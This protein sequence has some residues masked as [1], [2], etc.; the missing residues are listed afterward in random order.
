M[1]R[2][3]FDGVAKAERKRAPRDPLTPI[4]ATLARVDEDVFKTCDLESLRS[5]IGVV[6][7]LHK[8]AEMALWQRQ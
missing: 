4:I 5:F 1:P 3:V 2:R 6:E 7:R 8:S